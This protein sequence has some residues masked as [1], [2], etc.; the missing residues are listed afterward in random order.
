M[1]QNED[2][3]VVRAP[4]TT[5]NILLA[6]LQEIQED[7]KQRND[8]EQRLDVERQRRDRNRDIEVAQRKVRARIEPPIFNGTIPFERFLEDLNRY[9]EDNDIF[10]DLNNVAARK[11]LLFRF[12]GDPVKETAYNLDY[13]NELT[14]EQLTDLL[15]TRYGNE[16][17]KPLARQE[18]FHMK[19]EPR[20]SIFQYA[21]RVRLTI[22]SAYPTAAD[23]LQDDLAIDKFIM[24]LRDPEI[25]KSV[26]ISTSSTDT[27]DTVAG[28]A[29][30]IA[31]CLDRQALR[32]KQED[33]ISDVLNQIKTHLT[34]NKEETSRPRCSHCNGLHNSRDCR[35]QRQNL[36]QQRWHERPTCDF[37]GG[38]HPT[39]ECRRMQRARQGTYDMQQ[40]GNFLN[41]Q[42]NAAPFQRSDTPIK[43]A[44]NNR[45]AFQSPRTD[46]RKC[47]NC[48]GPHLRK[49]CPHL[50]SN[51]RFVRDAKR[52]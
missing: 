7:R 4:V 26:G 30:Q 31:N 3:D 34:L 2:E 5:E 14:Y 39:R 11:A 15:A 38:R 47:F 51:S 10:D 24:G 6:L 1:H 9:M 40:R 32:R 37:C 36:I 42:A 52:Q 35:R 45:D 28:K 19:Q 8:R 41:R 12:L 18:L 49:D 43:S 21:D 33:E 44:N 13:Q 20:E 22:N 25:A 27:L 17:K 23:P 29:Q 16:A 48:Y 46:E 50:N